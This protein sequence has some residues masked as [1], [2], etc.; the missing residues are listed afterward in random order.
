MQALTVPETGPKLKLVRAAEKLFA[1]N[2]FERVSV[3]DITNL[4]GAN[5][6][7][8][9]YH[10]GSRSGLV[11]AVMARYLK[12]INSERMA[13]LRA[14]ERKWAGKAV[15]LEEIVDAFAS[16]LV[17]RV[18]NSEMSEKLFHRL[19]GRILAEQ[20]GGMSPELDAGLEAE[21]RDLAQAFLK[22]L[23]KAL[24]SLGSEELVWRMHFMTG[25]LIHLLSHGELVGQ[26]GNRTAGTP[27]T[28][29]AYSRF[30]RFVS[31]G[32]RNG[33]KEGSPAADA[34]GNPQTEEADDGSQAF[35]DF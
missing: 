25:A 1:E 12:P 30:L 2:G 19:L 27:S 3:R 8:V 24:P 4:A 7:A 29:G 34:D 32:L 35:F 22:T 26:G 33:V 5:V 18:R 23:G 6:A 31:A 15:P 14:A 13:R 11:A 10:F 20:G 21:F 17:R 16:P 28:E 9:N